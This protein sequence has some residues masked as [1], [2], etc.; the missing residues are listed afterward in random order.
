MDLGIGR[1]WNT[2]I[3]LFAMAASEIDSKYEVLKCNHMDF[4][5]HLKYS[6]ALAYLFTIIETLSEI[7]AGSLPKSILS[8]SKTQNRDVKFIQF[9]NFPRLDLSVRHLVHDTDYETAFNTL[10]TMYFYVSISKGTML[11]E[12]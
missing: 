5:S 8:T 7:T 9:L 3:G 1:T 11:C 10:Y 12:R 6:A 2:V 4:F